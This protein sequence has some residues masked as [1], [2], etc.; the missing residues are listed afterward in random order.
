MDS[1]LLANVQNIIAKVY[2]TSTSLSIEVIYIITWKD[3]KIDLSKSEVN[4]KL[5]I[6]YLFIMYFNLQIKLIIK[7]DGDI[8]INS[9]II[10]FKP[11]NLCYLQLWQ[12]K[13]EFYK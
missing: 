4:A 2:N 5:L 7:I 1:T 6:S 12:Y 10:V 11:K 13:L 9:C 8:S 3:L